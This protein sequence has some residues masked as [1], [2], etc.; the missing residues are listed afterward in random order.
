MTGADGGDSDDGNDHMGVLL[1][2]I[3]GGGDGGDA[4]GKLSVP[5]LL[6]V[7]VE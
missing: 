1:M 4:D 5:R 3:S 6:A 7:R 2:V